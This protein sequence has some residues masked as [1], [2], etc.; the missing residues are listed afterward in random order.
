MF[1]F[2]I[3]PDDKYFFASSFLNEETF[4]TKIYDIKTKEIVQ[5]LEDINYPVNYI[6][7]SPYNQSFM[8][9]YSYLNY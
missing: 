4:F 3:S 5:T 9:G 7:F 1:Y 8:T 2:N 6:I